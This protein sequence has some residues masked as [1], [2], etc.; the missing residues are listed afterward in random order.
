LH[1]DLRLKNE[2]L[3]L[4]FRKENPDMEPAIVEFI[5]SAS[6]EATKK[7]LL[8]QFRQTFNKLKKMSPDELDMFQEKYC[9]G[10][11]R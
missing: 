1:E 7:A 11:S 5:L 6:F 4:K 10:S 8:V 3:S 2:E 9:A